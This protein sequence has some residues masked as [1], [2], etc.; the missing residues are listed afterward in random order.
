MTDLRRAIRGV[1]LRD[2]RFERTAL[3]ASTVRG[4][5]WPAGEPFAATLHAISGRPGRDKVRQ[6]VYTDRGAYRTPYDFYEM[7]GAFR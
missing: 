3:G 5:L 2:V 7:A 4:V 6:I 1:E